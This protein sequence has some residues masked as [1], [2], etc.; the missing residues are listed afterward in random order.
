[1]TEILNIQYHTRFTDP[2]RTDPKKLNQ[3]PSQQQLHLGNA[4]PAQQQRADAARLFSDLPVF[5]FRPRLQPPAPPAP[6]FR[7]HG[8]RAG[9]TS[10]AAGCLESPS[11]PSAG[12]P[13]LPRS[14]SSGASSPAAARPPRP[15]RLPPGGG[16]PWPAPPATPWPRW[17]RRPPSG[18]GWCEWSPSSWADSTSRCCCSGSISST[19]C[20]RRTATGGSRSPPRPAGRD[21]RALHGR[22]CA[23]AARHGGRHS[24]APSPRG[25]RQCRC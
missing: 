1:M 20:S 4:P 25:R 16:P 8:C 5:Y 18:S 15:R 6:A 17:W 13:P 10:A 23:R 11:S 12:P 7:G 21:P 19:P 14:S 22:R 2:Q 3:P 9:A 24:Q